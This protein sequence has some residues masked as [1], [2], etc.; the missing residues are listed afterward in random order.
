MKLVILTLSAKL[1]DEEA[2]KF[3]HN[4]KEFGKQA[5]TTF[6]MNDPKKELLLTWNFIS[7]KEPRR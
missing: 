2:A 3:E 4:L 7:A 6:D 5:L 1:S